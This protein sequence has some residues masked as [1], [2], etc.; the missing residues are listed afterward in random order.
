VKLPGNLVPIQPFT[1]FAA[2]NSVSRTM[3]SL[4]TSY[5]R[6]NWIRISSMRLCKKYTAIPSE[7]SHR[8]WMIRP[9]PELYLQFSSR[10][11]YH[12]GILYAYFKRTGLYQQR[13][14]VSPDRLISFH[15]P[16]CEATRHGHIQ[17]ASPSPS[18]YP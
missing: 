6:T 10:D 13:P 5:K 17:K 15:L 4:L 3:G 2:S 12:I 14:S 1:N 7:V 8:D 18:P 16:E 11:L 9:L